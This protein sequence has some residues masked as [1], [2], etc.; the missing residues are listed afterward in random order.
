[1]V[2]KIKV[3]EPGRD[4]GHIM[5]ALDEPKYTRTVETPM[6]MKVYALKVADSSNQPH[7]DYDG[8]KD[9]RR[10]CPDGCGIGVGY[11]YAWVK[12]GLVQAIRLRDSVFFP[13]ANAD[14]HLYRIARLRSR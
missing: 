5:V 13:Q 2:Y 9:T 1:M 10:S 14:R 11:V 7:F 8:F 6:R 4:S 3:D 12:D